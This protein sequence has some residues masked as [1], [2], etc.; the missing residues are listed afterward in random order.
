[1]TAN[2][3]RLFCHKLSKRRARG[4]NP[5]PLT[6]HFIS[7]EAASHSPTLQTKVNQEHI[8]AQRRSKPITS[9]FLG[10]C[11]SDSESVGFSHFRGVVILEE[12][13]NSLRIVLVGGV[14]GGA[15]AATRAR[16]VNAGAEITLL[17][18]NSV[19]SFANCG[20]PYHV[21]GEIEKRQSLIVAK[22]ELFWNRFRIHVKTKCEALQIDRVAK[23]VSVI[24]SDSGEMS[25]IP[26]DRLIL[27]TGAE[28][29]VPD[30]CVPMP[31]NAFHLW[32]L[33]DMDGIMAKLRS[34]TVSNAVVVGGGL[35]FYYFPLRF[36]PDFFE[37]KYYTK[38]YELFNLIISSLVSLI[39]IY[40]SVSL[41]A[42]E[43]F[44]QKSGVDFHK[45]F[46]EKI[47]GE[48]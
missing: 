22:K 31:C 41:V 5:Q 6:G 3:N 9:F 28:P 46:L 25:T 27:A 38:I 42:Y 15:S 2:A 8:L 39:G 1:M 29:N 19:V 37:I 34:D 48:L 18:R 32:T 10:F 23:T 12:Q 14:A 24:D 20:L 36:V 21:G 16:R 13:M 33:A 40:I 30:Y 43:F 26:Y 45:S 35:Q 17:E 7:N 11:H 47:T 4:S 44:K